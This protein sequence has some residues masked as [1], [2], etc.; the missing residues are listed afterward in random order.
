MFVVV[1]CSVLV[2]V[3]RPCGGRGRGRRGGLRR[4]EN[5]SPPLR[6]HRHGRRGGRSLGVR[7]D[8]AAPPSLFHVSFGE[9]ATSAPAE[10][11]GEI[12][13]RLA[14]SSK[15]AGPSAGTEV[16]CMR[17]W[18]AWCLLERRPRGIA[19]RQPSSAVRGP[20]FRRRPAVV[21]CLPCYDNY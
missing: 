14:K 11:G 17:R 3:R 1:C 15:Y 2:D 7:D 12:S 5:L 6:R 10:P 16:A 8:S 21:H 13:Q 19:A 9:L 18:H 4:A 20:V